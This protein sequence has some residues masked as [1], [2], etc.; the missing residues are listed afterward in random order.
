MESI[1]GLTNTKEKNHY[2]IGNIFEAEFHRVHLYGITKF[3]NRAFYGKITGTIT[4]TA[5]PGGR[6]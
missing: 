2:F 3:V 6:G 5:H 4:R 1:F